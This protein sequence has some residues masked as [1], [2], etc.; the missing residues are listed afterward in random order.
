LRA[1]NTQQQQLQQQQ[2]D[3]EQ[4]EDLVAAE[5][6]TTHLL[7]FFISHLSCKISDVL[8]ALYRKRR[9]HNVLPAVDAQ[10]H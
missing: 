2:A 5:V 7:L 6:N 3:A 9:L 1:Q 8:A 4:Q 10:D